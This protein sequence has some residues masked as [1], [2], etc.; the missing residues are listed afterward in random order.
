MNI[1][2]IVRLELFRN[3]VL[4]GICVVVSAVL[5]ARLAKRDKHISGQRALVLASLPILIQIA[6]DLAH[7]RCWLDVWFPVFV[8]VAL[9]Y[10]LVALVRCPIRKYAA[11]AVV[12]AFLEVLMIP[13]AMALQLGELFTGF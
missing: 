3:S 4:L 13:W 9:G 2:D 11:I 7:F 12:F 1:S 10:S 8:A 5:A 6:H